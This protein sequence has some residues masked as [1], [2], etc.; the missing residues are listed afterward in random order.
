MSVLIP[1][2][3]ILQNPVSLLLPDNAVNDVLVL[4]AGRA[5]VVTIVSIAI[6][7]RGASPR[8]V[9]V[10]WTEDTTDFAIFERS[11]PATDSVVVTDIP[12]KL[13]AKQTDRKIRA[14][15]PAGNE[16]TVTV[17]YTS[18]GQSNVGG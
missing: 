13:F 14:Q 7:N 2:S 15:A 4:D 5:D 12:V 17:F 8:K 1:V 11:V 18:V 6:V 9:T 3:G 16:V 10:W